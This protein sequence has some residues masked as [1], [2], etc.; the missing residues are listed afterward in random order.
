MQFSRGAAALAATAVLT[1]GLAACGEDEPTE[2]TTTA[3]PIEVDPSSSSSSGPSVSPSKGS[4][5]DAGADLPADLPAAAREE[6]KE[7]AAAFGKYYYEAF[8]EATHTGNTAVIEKLDSDSCLV[9]SDGVTNIKTDAKKGWTRSVNP[10]TVRNVRVTKRPDE[11]YKVAMQVKVVA[12]K[13]LDADGKANANVRAADYKLTEHIV[14]E[15]G[16]WQVKDWIV[17]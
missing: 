7:G 17:T 8:G 5:T 2:P 16:R 12:H 15:D 11:G 9:C 13:R 4:S 1:G 10:Y 6:T 14:W 3:S